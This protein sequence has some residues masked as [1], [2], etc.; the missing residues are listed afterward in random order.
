MAM[1]CPCIDAHRRLMDLHE[2]IH[3]ASENYLDS[4]EFRR[5]LNSAIQNS[6]G[7]TFLLQK[8]KAKW[9][10]FEGWYGDWQTA[11]RGNEVLIWGVGARN[12]IV[13]EEDL[14]TL[15]QAVISYYGER[16]KEAGDVLVVPPTV[17]VQEIVAAFA[18]VVRKRP[19]GRK[20]HIKVSRNGSTENFPPTNSSVPSES[21]TDPS[22]R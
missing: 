21:F 11:A 17:G 16:L 12:R 6:R 4:N 7:V 5:W 8:R 15:S 18:S 20:G 22:P 14:E 1:A 9:A 19:P 13:K 3:R 10:D 2:D